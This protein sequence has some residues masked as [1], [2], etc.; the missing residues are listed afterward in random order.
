MPA[1]RLIIYQPH[2]HYRIPF[3]V[4]RR[5]T[6]PI[7]PYSTVIGF[8]CNVCGINDQRQELYRDVIRKLKI[9]IAGRFEVKTT[10]MIWFRNLAKEN[11][12]N[13]YGHYTIREKNGQV[14]HPG[15]Q[16]PVKIDVLENVRLVIHLYHEDETALRSLEEHLRNPVNRLQVIHLGRA[17]DWIVYEDISVLNDEDFRYGRYDK[18]YEYFFWVPERIFIP[19]KFVNE[20]EKNSTSWDKFEGI[21]YILTTFSKIEGYE[22]HFN[23]N[24]KR[25]YERIRAKLNDG[26]IRGVKVLFDKDVKLPVFFMDASG[27]S[28]DAKQQAGQNMGQV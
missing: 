16:M 27:G 4:A 11:H 10:E 20:G 21:I 22:T 12:E 25:H 9:S 28:E 6:Y 1:L 8:L 2:A 24:A 5:H 14:G 23:H 15:G 17:E 3:S 19:S 26:G 13:F 18:N 7:P